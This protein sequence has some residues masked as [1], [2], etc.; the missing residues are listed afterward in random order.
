MAF[1]QSLARHQ[2]AFSGAIFPNRFG[3]IL[4]AAGVKTAILAQHRAD[5]EF[6]PAQQE[7]K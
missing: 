1:A 4:G 3:G 7:Q 2:T 5:R 6:I